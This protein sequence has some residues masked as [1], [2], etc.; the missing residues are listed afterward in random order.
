MFKVLDI[1]GV[2]HIIGEAEEA[3]INPVLAKEINNN[4]YVLSTKEGELFNPNTGDNVKQIDKNRGGKK[5]TLQKCTYKCF[6]YYSIF[7]RT[8]NRIHY[9]I[10]EKELKNGT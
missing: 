4:C 1:N 3:N 6:I 7:L 2:P 5:F 8:K 9:T 10:A